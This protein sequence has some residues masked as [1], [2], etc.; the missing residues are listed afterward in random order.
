MNYPT[1]Y[2]SE[3]S[4]PIKLVGK[5]GKAI[6]ITIHSPSEYIQTNRDRIFPDW[7]NQTSFWVVIVLQQ[8]Q[9]EMLEITPKVEKEKQQLREN[10]MRFGFDVVFHL[11]DGG[12]LSDLI[13]PRT[14]YPLLSRPGEIPH[15]DTAAVKALLNYP[16]IRNKCR[17]LIHPQWGISV[18]PS[19]FIST[20]N[21][22]VIELAIKNIAPDHGWK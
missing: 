22:T 10:F 7:H 9:Y 5:M 14:G 21:P 3:Q 11:R 16:I 8:S 19:I 4:H 13:D 2:P 1:I 6:Q 17:V 20:A 12:Y 18:Y 15:D